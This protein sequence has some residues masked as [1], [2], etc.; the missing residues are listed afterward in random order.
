MTT[1]WLRL[2]SAE[3]M[4]AVR[5]SCERL[6]L[7]SAEWTHSAIAARKAATTTTP[8]RISQTTFGSSEPT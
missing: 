2:F 6:T 5:R 8:I 3:L 4:K 1:P 7:R